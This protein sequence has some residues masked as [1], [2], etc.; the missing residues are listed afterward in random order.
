[1]GPLLELNL[2]LLFH[3][4]TRLLYIH[5]VL[6]PRNKGTTTPRT[7]HHG[8]RHDEVRDPARQKMAAR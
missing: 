7:G 4:Q 6:L 5:K 8:L 1:M 2:H 3:V